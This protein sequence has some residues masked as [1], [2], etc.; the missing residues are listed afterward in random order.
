MK[1]LNFKSFAVQFGSTSRQLKPYVGV[2]VF[3]LFA[4]V[5]GFVIVRIN[6]LS[7]AQVSDADVAAQVNASPV[8]RID[9]GAIKQLQSLNDNSVNV[10]SLFQQGRTN[11]FQE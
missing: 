1:G 4:L 2:G 11:P 10:Q 8:P 7:D 9:A 5:Y 6:S 3:L